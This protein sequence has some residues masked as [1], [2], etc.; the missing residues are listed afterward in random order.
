MRKLTALAL[1]LL[2]GCIDRVGSE[3]P[4]GPAYEEVRTLSGSKPGYCFTCL[5]GFDM[6]MN[7]SLKFSPYC[8]CTY[9]AKVTVQPVHVRL[10]S[11][12]LLNDE[13]VTERKRICDC[14]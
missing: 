7:C 6:K 5:P 10:E 12:K 9:K 1:L 3:E 4:A 8:P 14:N 13:R 2:T 11:G